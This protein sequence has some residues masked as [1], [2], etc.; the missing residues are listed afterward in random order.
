MTSQSNPKTVELYGFCVQHE[1]KAG[2]TITPGMLVEREADAVDTVE[3]HGT[4][5]GGGNAH[6]AV[7]YDLT[8]RDL[9]D[10]YASGDQVI[11]KTFYPGAGVYAL[12]A[13]AEPAIL[14]AAKLAS[15]GD[16]Y[17]SEA[18]DGDIVI[19]EA[20]EAVDNSAGAAAA[21]I[22]VEIVQAYALN[23]ATA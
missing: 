19:A 6:F 20:R 16:G 7:E 3:P 4:A 13:A 22:K 9:D 2:A 18:A 11:F 8:G 21:R 23:P 10:N 14:K 12:V 1:A 17:L 5:G 15:A